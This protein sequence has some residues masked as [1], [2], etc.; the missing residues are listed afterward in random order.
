[1]QGMQMPM[2]GMQVAGSPIHVPMPV[3]GADSQTAMAAAAQAAALAN[4]AAAV[5]MWNPNPQ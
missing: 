2:Q 3:M 4:A 5:G 1:M